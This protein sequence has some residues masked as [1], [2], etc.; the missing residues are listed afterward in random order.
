M[1]SIIKES[2]IKKAIEEA[3]NSNFYPYHG[4]V[5]FKGSKIISIGNNQIRYCNKL[6]IKYKKWI[7]SLHAEQK[8][9]IFSKKDVKRCSLLVIRINREGELKYSKPC[10]VCRQFINDMGISKVFYSNKNGEIVQ[11]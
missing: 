8:A 11:L 7:N 10:V 3:K 2:I 5:I 6:N 1:K 4:C 9:I